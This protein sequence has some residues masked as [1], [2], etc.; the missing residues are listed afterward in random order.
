MKDTKNYV[1][2]C[3]LLESIL[4]FKIYF[5]IISA[6][7]FRN[8]GE[9][10]FYDA[11]FKCAVSGLVAE[12]VAVLVLGLVSVSSIT[13]L[14]PFLWRFFVCCL[15]PG[16]MGGRPR[17]PPGSPDH[18]GAIGCPGDPLGAL[19]IT[20]ELLFAHGAQGPWAIV[21][22]RPPTDPYIQVTK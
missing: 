8:L 5:Q 20:W 21:D 15:H 19:G 14:V 3:L 16:S 17:A 12:L 6:G 13:S 2:Q 22:G 10:S 7:I 9:G 11:P 1:F 18:R 4:N